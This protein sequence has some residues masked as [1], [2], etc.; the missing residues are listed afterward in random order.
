MTEMEANSKD[1]TLSLEERVFRQL[2]EDIITGYYEKGASLTELGICER[3]GVSRTPVRS[4]LHRLAEEGLVS[5]AP[6]R[7]AFVIGVTKDDLTDTYKIRMRLEGLASRM[8]TERLTDEVRDELIHALELS[9]F[10]AT[11]GDVERFK[12]LDTSFHALIYRASGNRMLSKI[13][14][15]LHRNV[16]AYRKK[17]L[18]VPG[19]ME[20][21]VKEHKEILAAMLA[22]DA[23]AADSLTSRHVE[24]AMENLANIC[25]G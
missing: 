12:E 11:K 23:D 9:E 25:D 4:A 20:S 15:E 8:A 10:Y 7:G 21:S 6:N 3:L 22:G 14:G 19:R 16:R 17:S 18:S 24:R 2:E 5:I 1:I 13:L